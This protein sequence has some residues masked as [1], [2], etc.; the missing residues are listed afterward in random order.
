MCDSPINGN[1]TLVNC[2]SVHIGSKQSTLLSFSSDPVLLNTVSKFLVPNAKSCCHHSYGVGGKDKPE[3]S[4]SNCK[5][6]CMLSI[7][8]KLQ[9]S[10]TQRNKLRS[11]G[12]R[13]AYCCM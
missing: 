6:F 2:N 5:L 11:S 13:L 10:S 1:A 8:Y 4:R 12:K 9:E 3:M 7:G